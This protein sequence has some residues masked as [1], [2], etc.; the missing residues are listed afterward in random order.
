MCRKPTN[1][2]ST[3]LTI[4]QR[5]GGC[6]GRNIDV[7]H[8]HQHCGDRCNNDDGEPCRSMG[9]HCDALR[10]AA[11]AAVVADVV[12]V[13]VVAIVWLHLMMMMFCLPF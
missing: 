8:Q 3:L 2:H 9:S 1:K 12:V 11:H 10:I 7:G 13:V 4:D 5:I 6:S